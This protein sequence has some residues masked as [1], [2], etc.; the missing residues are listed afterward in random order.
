MPISQIKTDGI[1]SDAVTQPKIKDNITLDGTE[2]VRVPAGTTAQRPSSAAGGQLRFNTDIG[3]LEQYNTLTSAWQAIDSPPII[4]SVTLA[5]SAT[6]ANPAGGETVTITGS[7]FKAG[8]T[9]TIG[10]TAASS[11]TI[12]STTQITITLPAKTAG[13]YDV[14]VTNT[15]GLAATATNAI[16]YNGT[17]A[18]TTASGNLGS[19]AEDVAMSTITIVAAEP[20]GGTLAY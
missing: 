1:A 7:N 13:D 18:F 3:T 8:A 16:S 9:V 19:L 15:N 6:A 11:V 2:F 5:G 14:V 17:P 20:D 12:N 4:T 10:T